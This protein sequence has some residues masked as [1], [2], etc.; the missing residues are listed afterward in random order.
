MDWELW[1][2]FSVGDHLR[3]RAFIADVLLY[4]H[5]VVPAPPEDDDDEWRRWRKMGWVPGR[6]RR[7]LDLMG[8]K[9]V[10][11][12]PWTP[13]H[14]EGWES[15]YQQARG[16]ERAIVRNNIA[17]AVAGDASVI[18][19]QR[20]EF[21]TRGGRPEEVD[22]LAHFTTRG[23]LVDW[24]NQRR[25]TA[26]FMGI[27]EVSVDA[28]AAYGSY[29]AF[30]RDHHIAVEKLHENPRSQA[31]Y[32]FGWELLVPNDSR[33]SD[34]DLL[35]QALELSDLDET[36]RHRQAFHRWRREA[37]LAGK[38]HDEALKDMEELINDYRAAVRKSKITTGAKYGFAVISA[39]AT[40]A[41][42]TAFPPIAV[43]GVGAFATMGSFVAAETVKTQIPERLQVA[44]MFHDARKRFGWYWR[45]K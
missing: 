8:K 3:R 10:V 41:A 12:V 14:R 40:L 4:D 33:L 11:E 36:K 44:A 34:E 25:D 2:T 13:G 9:R 37:T 29:S 28:V 27:P 1:G 24:W 20:K 23:Y 43:A 22:D 26:L 42:A 16:T 6:Q 31:L 38:T 21:K 32:L 18:V 15:L 30:G 5:L 45:F 17:H 35:K 7:I 39:G 19:E